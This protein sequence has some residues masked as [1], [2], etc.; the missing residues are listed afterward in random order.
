M[1]FNEIKKNKDPRL[2]KPRDP[3]FQAMV[4]LKKSGAG[5]SHGDKTKV[6]PRKQKHQKHPERTDEI[7]PVL[8]MGAMYGY[9]AYQVYR[10]ARAVRMGSQIARGVSAIDKAAKGAK[11]LRTGEKILRHGKKLKIPASL[12]KPVSDGGKIVKDAGRLLGK[13]A[14][15]V[16]KVA[17]RNPGKTAAIGG[18][19]WII[20]KFPDI[21]EEFW[22]FVKKYGIPAAAVLAI[23]YG[24]TKL[25]DYFQELGDEA[26]KD[27]DDV[28]NR[29]EPQ[30][31]EDIDESP[32]KQDKDNPIAKPYADM[33]EWKALHD[34]DDEIIQAY[35][36]HKT[37]VSEADD[38]APARLLG[39]AEAHLGYGLEMAQYV[40]SGDKFKAESMARTIVDGWP[41]A[42]DKI[43]NVYK[44]KSNGESIK[45]FIDDRVGTVI[46]TTQGKR[47]K[48][49]QADPKNGIY[50]VKFQNGPEVYMSR[51]ELD[52]EVPTDALGK[53]TKP[54]DWKHPWDIGE[55]KEKMCPEACCGVPV[56][57]CHCPPDCPHCDCNAVVK[58]DLDSKSHKAYSSMWHKSN[59]I[60]R[61]WLDPDDYDADAE[62][63][64]MITDTPT[65]MHI[66]KVP[67]KN[68]D[69]AFDKWLDGKNSDRVQD[70]EFYDSTKDYSSEHQYWGRI[71]P[72]NDEMNW[73]D[74]P[75][76]RDPEDDDWTDDDEKEFGTAARD[77]TNVPGRE[78]DD[79]DE[80]EAK[81]LSK[82][83]KEAFMSEEKFGVTDLEDYREKMKTLYSLERYMKSDP[84]L[85]DEV[86]RRYRELAT[87][88]VNYDKE[89]AEN[90]ESQ[91]YDGMKDIG[92]TA[93]AGSTSAGAIAT[94]ANPVLA[95]HN[96][97][98][99]GKF[100]APKAPQKKKADGTTV[101][102]L[103]MGNNLMGGTPVKR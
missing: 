62:G 47:A 38:N 26:K 46:R 68:Y 2:I 53:T 31:Q 37:N 12:A 101:N 41:D 6:I 15:G 96:P 43:H 3:N 49:V 33:P 50:K 23:L 92:E 52:L 86:R 67:A 1:R 93:T 77:L 74:H 11:A 30:P 85:A 58:E 99:K 35:I 34:M 103:D 87:W 22:E 32:I 98:K 39:V 80:E 60:G 44:R 5:G 13:G 56:S 25:Y 63:T 61:N 7:L 40:L 102:A 48:I 45:E 18:M 42:I 19:A 75:S 76:N 21:P 69:E 100:G 79:D 91:I 90:Y 36:K 29:T 78:Y 57:E 9:R 82:D 54:R 28:M 89:N 17:A 14:K 51:D 84:E 20:D 16:G 59:P 94:V 81:T 95:Y 73:P 72:S 24:G 27:N 88:K 64:H 71:D 55:A 66:Y 70:H 97:K 8:A 10:L 83:K 4:D 65:E